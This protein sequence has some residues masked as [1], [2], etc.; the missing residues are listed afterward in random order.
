MKKEIRVVDEKRSIIQCTSYD[1][2]FY[3]IPSTDKSTGLPF[4]KFLPSVTHIT[5]FYP[6]GKGFENFLKKVGDEAELIKEIAGQKGSKIHQAVT[7]L[8]KG[9]VVNMQ[10]K[11]INN[12]TGVNEELNAEEYEAVVS[13]KDWFLITK[14]KI[15]AF[16]ITVINEEVGYAGTLDIDCEIGG[17]STIIDIKSS[18]NIYTSHILQLSAYQHT[19]GNENKD[20][21]ILQLGYQRNKNRYKY[22]PIEDKFNLFLATKEIYDN[23]TKDKSP[24][25]IE[26]PLEIKLE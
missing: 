11:F 21:A 17:K 13:F 8:L 4:Y 5:T 22:T 23:E 25:T 1:E 6:K 9:F 14:P 15:T 12:L 26:L 18:P 3:A 16:E 24:L 2:R 19:F 7:H 20:L 10:S